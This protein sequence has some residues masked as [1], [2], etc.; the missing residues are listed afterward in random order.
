MEDWETYKNTQNFMQAIKT[1]GKN[2]FARI[3]IMMLMEDRTI[4]RESLDEQIT[5]FEDI[6]TEK[7]QPEILY[8][9]MLVRAYTAYTYE[10]GKIL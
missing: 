9:M 6:A 1:L 2:E 5:S 4:S 7:N 10:I 3:A 8:L